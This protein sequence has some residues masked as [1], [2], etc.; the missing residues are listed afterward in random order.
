VKLKLADLPSWDGEHD[1]AVKYFF[2]VSQK[3]SL[4]G[5]I[6]ELLGQWLG[7]RLEEGSPVQVWYAGLPGD[8]Q[9]EMRRHYIFFLQGI[10]EYYLGRTWQRKMNR[11]YELQK[12]RQ[13]GYE[14]EMPRGYLGRRI[15]WTRMLVAT[16]DGGPGEVHHVMEKAPVSWGP[17]LILENIVS[18][19]TLYSKV[20][21]HE[22]AL[23][24]AWKSESSRALTADNLGAA[25]KALGY[26]PEKP[27]FSA[28]QVHFNAGE[29]TTEESNIEESEDIISGNPAEDEIFRQVYS[30]L[31]AKKRT[32]PP[33]GYPFPK[34]D[35]V[36]TK[37]GKLPPGPC[38][39]CGSE[40]HW[41]KE[42]PN[43]VV[44]SEGVRRNAN[45]VAAMEPSEEETMY[46]SLFSVLLNQTLA[47]TTIDYGS[48][49]G[50]FFV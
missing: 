5:M 29:T 32:D 43:Y 8:K 41:N 13:R 1:T 37:L 23:V 17:I 2:D 42:C 35:H 24:N 44:Y 48:L 7:M 6:P 40:K 36:V 31:K 46:Q 4:G 14:T 21:E 30:T 12:F 28:K 15:M 18:T 34:N 16:D 27:R 19:M 26:S 9:A 50:S 3:A 20:V 38:R 39:L 11:D 22:L 25:L 45:L 33:G 49:E 47:K 10:K